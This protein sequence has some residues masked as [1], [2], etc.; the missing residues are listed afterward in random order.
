MENRYKAIEID[1]VGKIKKGDMPGDKIEIGEGHI[2]KAKTI[3]PVL[4]GKLLPV[5]EEHGKAVVSVHGGSGVGKSEIGALLAYYLNAV[6]IGTYIL[7]GDNYPHRIPM[8]NDAERLRVFREYGMKGLVESGE[9]TLGKN[10]ILHELQDN[11]VDASGKDYERYPWLKHYHEAG[12]KALQAYLGTEREIDFAEVNSIIGKF[13]SGAESIMLKRM[14]RDVKELWY[15]KVDF[16]GIK[17]MIIE[18]THG[19]SPYL[20]GVDIPILLYSTPEETLEH[21]RK[22]NRDKGLDSPFTMLVL[23][24]E[25]RKL[26]DQAGN[27]KIIVSKDGEIMEKLTGGMEK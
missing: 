10:E 5:I 12:K 9:Y 11:D 19:N 18:W 6:E 15:D 26:F 20:N 13:K 7:S 3:F 14:G 4:M 17:V 21:R 2:S 24:I 25:Q 1:D 16:S 23:D 27:A 22:R 8:L